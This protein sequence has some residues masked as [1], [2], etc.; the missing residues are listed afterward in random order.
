M[1]TGLLPDTIA[2]ITAEKTG[3]I[4]V[5]VGPVPAVLLCVAIMFALLYPLDRDTFARI[6][7]ELDRRR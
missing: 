2:A 4:R 6:R 5:L 3:V 1:D 7:S